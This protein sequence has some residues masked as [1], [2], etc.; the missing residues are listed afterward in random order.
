MLKQAKIG[1]FWLVV[2]ERSSSSSRGEGSW[3]R[4]GWEIGNGARGGFVN[5]QGRR[6]IPID[7]G[8]AATATEGLQL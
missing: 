2:G 3:V 6:Q 8:N 4:A 1:F 7:R 5:E